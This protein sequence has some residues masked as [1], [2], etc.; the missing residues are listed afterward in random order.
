[1]QRFY[2]HKL[3]VSYCPREPHNLPAYRHWTKWWWQVQIYEK[4]DHCWSLCMRSLYKVV[5]EKIGSADGIYA[6][7][8]SVVA[9]LSTRMT[10]TTDWPCE[11]AAWL[12][13]ATKGSSQEQK[14]LKQRS[15]FRRRSWSKKNGLHGVAKMSV[16]HSFSLLIQPN[17]WL[18]WFLVSVS[19]TV[20]ESFRRRMF[21][22]LPK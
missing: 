7:V 13:Q 6:F 16:K 20:F 5:K 4:T 14:C 18:F 22:N 8:C 3:P 19:G 15:P 1:M 10:W 9:F 17:F 12:M 11:H 21:V 2:S